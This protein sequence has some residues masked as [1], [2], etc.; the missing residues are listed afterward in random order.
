MRRGIED[1]VLFN[2]PLR[3]EFSHATAFRTR[4]LNAF[5]RSHPVGFAASKRVFNIPHTFS[6]GLRSG[7]YGG[8]VAHS[9]PGRWGRGA[10]MH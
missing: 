6:M 1:T 8:N 2:A 3:V 5:S 10:C 9:T 7:E 4:R